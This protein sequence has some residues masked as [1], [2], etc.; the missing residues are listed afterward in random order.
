MHR[1][2]IKLL[3]ICIE[4]P[5]QGV[6]CDFDRFAGARTLL[7][8]GFLTGLISSDLVFSSDDLSNKSILCDEI[9]YFCFQ[10]IAE[11]INTGVEKGV[12]KENL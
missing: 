9:F 11:M 5:I 12:P 7:L 1:I 8:S 4:N 10:K 3:N 2:Q 6:S